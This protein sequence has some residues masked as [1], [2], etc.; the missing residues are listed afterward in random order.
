[1]ASSHV[2]DLN[3]HHLHFSILDCFEKIFQTG[4]LDTSL[5]NLDANINS[6]FLF[7]LGETEYR[8]TCSFWRFR[9]EHML[10]KS[11]SESESRSVVLILCDPV[12]YTLHGIIQ[13]R[14]LE[15]VAFPFSRGS[16]Q[17]RGWTQVSHIADRFF[18][19]R[20]TREAQEYWSG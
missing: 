20:A 15:W 6:R 10:E 18:T 9:E 11:W 1:M 19:R 17:P 5:G 16:S 3:P 8:Y 13:A 4:N 12:D 7:Y 2:F 14:I